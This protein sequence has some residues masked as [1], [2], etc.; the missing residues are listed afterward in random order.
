[1]FFLI[2]VLM[3][4][5]GL[6]LPVLSVLSSENNDNKET[7]S[8]SEGNNMGSLRCFN[9]GSIINSENENCYKCGAATITSVMLDRS[10]IA[11]KVRFKADNGMFYSGNIVNGNREGY[12]ICILP[13]GSR[14]EG[15][16]KNNQCV[17]GRSEWSDGEC[18]E[19]QFYNGLKHGIGKYS[20]ADGSTYQGEYKNDF[21]DGKGIFKNAMT[22]ISVECYFSMGKKSGK[23]AKIIM[24]NGTSFEGFF[25]EDNVWHLTNLE[26]I[27]YYLSNNI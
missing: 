1:M 12:G 27:K 5:V 22:G 10:G 20:Y 23:F 24:P 9:C 13:D 25:D 4:V 8:E 14:L 16:W 17:D 2:I 19:G 11:H 3:F 15:T 26:Y 18:Y 7:T 21:P 6:G